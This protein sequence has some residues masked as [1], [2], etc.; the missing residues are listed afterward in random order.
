[1]TI[2]EPWLLVLLAAAPLTA[3]A[4]AWAWRRRSAAA[5][6]YAPGGPVPPAPPGRAVR[7]ALLSSAAVLL[8]LAAAR[9][10]I[11]TRTETAP[12]QGVEVVFALD[13]S[14]SMLTAD[15]PPDRLT[16]AIRQIDT[17]LNRLAGSRV[18]LVI[19]A[20]NG[21]L[22]APLTTDIEAV[23]RLLAS[24]ASDARALTPG[25]N[26]AAGIRSSVRALET[27]QS[28]SRAIV[29]VSDGEDHVGNAA[30]AAAEAAEKG[31]VVHVAGVGTE[32]GGPVIERDPATGAI[33]PR[34]DPATG[35]LVVSR[36]DETQ[37]RAIA[38]AGGG[39]YVPIA[40]TGIEPVAEAL[41]R[42]QAARFEDVTS[43]RPVERFQLFAVA[44]FALLV[45]ERLIAGVAGGLR[46][47]RAA[48]P[49][50]VLVAAFI[51]VACAADADDHN[52]SGNRYYAQG[53][54]G[55]A[56]R[57]YRRAQAADPDHPVPMFN[58][59]TT[60]YRLEAYERAAGELR[61]VTAAADAAL[62]ARAWYNLGN[63]YVRLGRLL[64]ARA[65]YR[66]ALLL[67][68]DNRDAKFNLELVNRALLEQPTAEQPPSRGTPPGQP[69][70]GDAPEAGDRGEPS[71]G[72]PSGEGSPG[73]GEPQAGGDVERALEEALAGI[74][75]E[76]TLEDA[77]R[78]LDLLRQRQAE[79]AIGGARS[80][81]DGG[82]DY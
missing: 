38:E 76:F 48:L 68:P 50:A 35:G 3:L 69:P 5:L 17:L 11:G 14:L 9:P 53:R 55:E 77:L 24:A 8:G 25:S 41:A 82:P 32:R 52:D 73:E 70:P 19:F 62:R 29:L 64:D 63:A 57:E 22:R 31:I 49:A 6:R 12:Q 58:A 72:A 20:D 67:E 47:R 34:S 21:L 80:R 74:E 7:L 10:A 79:G 15:V 81:T 60:L 75:R 16:V 71:L 18:G 40:E 78:V 1:M 45:L 66:E 30:A 13:V 37:L 27:A 42:L 4:G 59:A 2:Q 43:E 33:V 61:A 44:G 54:Y 36:L 28:G 65:A 51:G 26:L 46:P 23:R 56:L 39:R